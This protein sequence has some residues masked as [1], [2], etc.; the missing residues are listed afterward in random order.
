M[1]RR[2]NTRTCWDFENEQL[3]DGLVVGAH[4]NR[5]LV[6]HHT[7]QGGAV[8]EQGLT[9]HHMVHA[10][11]RTAFSVGRWGVGCRLKSS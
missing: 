10:G 6:S 2:R 8:A 11:N 7:Q 4:K 9:P 1:R 3:F 5:R